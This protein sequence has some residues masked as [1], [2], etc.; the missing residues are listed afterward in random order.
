MSWTLWTVVLAT[1]ALPAC[2]KPK[3]AEEYELKAAFLFNIAKFVEWPAGAFADATSP[4]V[5]CIAGPD[6]FGTRIDRMLSGQSVN[7]RTFRVARHEQASAAQGCHI[8]FTTETP[9]PSGNALSLT[10]GDSKD[11]C[12]KGGMVGLRVEGERLVFETNLAALRRSGIKI[13]AQ[14]LKLARIVEGA[15]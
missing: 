7:A 12:T 3:A 2:A 6:P 1:A 10:V 5:V 8:V 9:T 13:S 14:L 4:I 11:F 15:A